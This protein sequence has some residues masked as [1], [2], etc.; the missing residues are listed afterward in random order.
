MP[1]VPIESSYLLSGSYAYGINLIGICC[2]CPCAL[3]LYGRYDYWPSICN[4]VRTVV[5]AHKSLAVSRKRK[6][7]RI[8]RRHDVDWKSWFR[9][10]RINPDLGWQKSRLMRERWI[11]ITSFD[12][13]DRYRTEVMHHSGAVRGGKKKKILKLPSSRYCFVSGGTILRAGYLS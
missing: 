10:N 13:P 6:N 1:N 8:P 9:R 11:S 4:I 2:R 12:S 7:A 3:I 5:R